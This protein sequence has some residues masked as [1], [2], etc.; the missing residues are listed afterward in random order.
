MTKK[1]FK[2]LGLVVGSMIGLV[3]IGF[4]IYIYLYYPRNVSSF[5]LHTPH[6][7]K[8]ILL[9]TQGSDFKNTLITNLCDSLSESSFYIKGI[10]VDRLPDV[11]DDEWD[12]ILIVNTFMVRLN[13]R[14]DHFL[15]R[16][17]SPDHVLLYV[18]SG[19]ADWQPQPD[20]KVDA[21][22]SASRKEHINDVT[23]L[24][25]DWVR[26][27]NN[28]KW[29][30]YDKVLALKY[31]SGVDVEDACAEIMNNQSHYTELHPDLVRVI[32]S[33]GYQYLRLNDLET[34]LEVFRLNK[35]LF[36]DFWNVYDSYGEALLRKGEV[37]AAIRN[38]ERA[39]A[40]NPGSESTRDVLNRLYD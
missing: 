30:Q 2:I 12:R 1:V 22:T 5:E 7:T 14:V 16:N 19:G 4:S 18:T 31:F 32:N 37:Q 8:N 15:D 20:L 26:K 3:L 13:R 27:D 40:L 34:A 33:I 21:I 10:D 9:A 11:N 6:P 24:I 38:Y 29:K 17:D 23:S 25:L 35:S 28:V 36:P 39:L